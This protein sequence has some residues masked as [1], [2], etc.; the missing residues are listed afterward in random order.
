MIFKEIVQYKYKC[1]RYFQ[2]QQHFPINIEGK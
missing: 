1:E 2:L